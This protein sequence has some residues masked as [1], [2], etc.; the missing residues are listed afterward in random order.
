[1]D[2]QRFDRLAKTLGGGAT[3]RTVL[4]T[5]GA[6][7]G[8]ALL[9][10]LGSRG[11]RAVAVTCITDA[12]CD[13]LGGTGDGRCVN[14]LCQLCIS[15]SAVCTGADLCCDGGA[16]CV[17]G[18]CTVGES[19]I[20]IGSPCGLSAAGVPAVQCCDGLTCVDE[21]CAPPCSGSGGDCDGKGS[22]CCTGFT[23]ESGS[24]V[25]AACFTAGH[26]C[27]DNTNCCAGLVCS[28]VGD[29]GGAICHAACAPLADAC[30]I[31]SDCCSGLVC[32][33]LICAA[34]VAGS[35]TVTIHKAICPADFGDPF[36][37]CHGNVLAGVAFSIDGFEIGSGVITTGADG[38]ASKTILQAAGE[39]GV[40]VTEDAAVFG[41][42]LGAYV[43]CSEQGSGAVLFGGSAPAGAVSF[44]AVQGDDI[45]CDWYNLT[46]ATGGVVETPV[47]TTTAT[48]TKTPTGGTT[49]LP[50]TGV[51]G[52]SGGAGT[53]I[54]AAALGGAAAYLAG[55]KLRGDAAGGP[56]E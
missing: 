40:T 10:M 55:R 31:D 49:T 6:G 8:G 28:S 48:A 38:V 16:R 26:A 25:A 42:Y 54:G 50:S 45:V 37:E 13:V 53:W 32:A 20:T 22:E 47:A 15:G 30:A 5:I 43:V 2:G 27:D 23:C 17:A 4:K 24:C 7:L 44:N 18:L 21:V 35:A 9:G 51:P 39:G 14:E 12:E 34:P 46:D 19:C 41:A 52:G 56:A 33:N 11:A 1:M 29:T 36:T 3:R